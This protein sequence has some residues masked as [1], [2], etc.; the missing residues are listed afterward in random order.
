[1]KPTIGGQVFFAVEALAHAA[2]LGQELSGADAS[3][4]WEAHDDLAVLE[5]SDVV[6]DT[7]GQESNLLDQA[8]QSASKRSSDH[9]RTIGAS[10]ACRAR[11]S[12]SHSPLQ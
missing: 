11:S 7:A 10:S 5:R 3:G 2:E 8:L 6:L 9:G 12:A 1:M 4:A